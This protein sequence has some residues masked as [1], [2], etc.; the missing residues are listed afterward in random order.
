[1]KRELK[2]QWRK[3]EAENKVVM[4]NKENVVDIV[5]GGGS[6]RKMTHTFGMQRGMTIGANERKQAHELRLPT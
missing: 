3:T 4:A 1:M 2:Q 6:L 5:G